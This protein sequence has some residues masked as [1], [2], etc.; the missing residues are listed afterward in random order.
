L[1]LIARESFVLHNCTEELSPTAYIMLIT[2]HSLLPSH[3]I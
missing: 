1:N 2:C 3:W